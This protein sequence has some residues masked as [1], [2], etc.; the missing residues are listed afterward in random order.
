ME[1][2]E[3]LLALACMYAIA[4]VLFLAIRKNKEEE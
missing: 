3:S 2:R 4:L 1:D